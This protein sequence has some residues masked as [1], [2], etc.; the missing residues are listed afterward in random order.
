VTFVIVGAV[1]KPLTQEEELYVALCLEGKLWCIFEVVLFDLRKS[2][3]N[4]VLC[5]REVV[6]CSYACLFF[7][8]EEFSV[9]VL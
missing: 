5:V 7:F 1:D 9:M 2:T 8:Y 6:R 3:M 4:P